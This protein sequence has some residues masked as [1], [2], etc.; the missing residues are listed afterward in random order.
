ML[1]VALTG[2]IAAGK[3][4]VAE[5]FRRWGATVIDA[6]AIVRELQRPG[7]PVL[8]RHRGAVRRRGAAARRLARPPGAAAGSSWP[9]PMPAPALK[10]IV[11]PAVDARRAELAAEARGARR[12]DRGE[13][14]PPA[15]RGR[16]SRRRSTPSCWWTRPSRCGARRLLEQRG[17]APAEADRTDRAPSCRPRR[18]GRGATTSSTTTA[19]SP[20]WSARRRTVWQRAASRRA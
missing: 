12:S 9:T 11:H 16:R 7:T 10:R 4:T 14:H 13:R 19:I 2:N 1:N 15:L 20:R 5:L 18:S 3:S 8:R 6:D 17:L